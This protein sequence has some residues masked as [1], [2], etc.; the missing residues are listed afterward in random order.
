MIALAQLPKIYLKP[1]E[2]TINEHPAEVATVLGSCVAV[3]LY[4]PRYSVGAICHAMLPRGGGFKYVDGALRHML[5]VFDH[6][7]IPRHE[8]ETKLFGGSDM[9][10]VLNL[11]KADTV[12]RQNVAMAQSLLKE[13]GL[14]PRVADVGGRQGRKLIFY[15][16]TGEVFLKR[17]NKNWREG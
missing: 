15:P 13:E 1:G 11:T 14:V 10:P 9:F 4:S 2:L 17:L 8:I 6:L 7:G 16:H 3:T 5:E 12:G